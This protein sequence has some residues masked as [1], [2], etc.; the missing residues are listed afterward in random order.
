MD[1]DNE[2]MGAWLEK[3]MLGVAEENVDLLTAVVPIPY[4]ILM[5]V[6]L[7]RNTFTVH[8]RPNKN[9]V[10]SIWFAICPGERSEINID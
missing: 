6:Y 3:Q 2:F 5:N 8:G 7:A 9:V 4:T 10:E 1:D